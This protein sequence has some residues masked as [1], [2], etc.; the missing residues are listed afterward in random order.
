MLHLDVALNH[1]TRI[2]V[3]YCLDVLGQRFF[4]PLLLLI[5]LVSVLLANLSV[6]FAREVG[7]QGDVSCLWEHSFLQQSL[8]LEVVIHL[9]ELVDGQLVVFLPY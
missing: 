6:D 3:A 1:V 9:I 4:R 8:D 2:Q 7:S 5:Q